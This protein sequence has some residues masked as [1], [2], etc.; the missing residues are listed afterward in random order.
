MSN[1]QAF[2]VKT[3]TRAKDR[4]PAPENMT[5]NFDGRKNANDTLVEKNGKISK[6]GYKCK[7]LCMCAK[8]SSA[9]SM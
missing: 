2:W 6:S 4:K 5:G 1:P 8:F 3:R 7:T 9:K